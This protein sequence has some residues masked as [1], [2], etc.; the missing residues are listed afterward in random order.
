MRHRIPAGNLD[1]GHS[2]ARIWICGRFVWAVGLDS[3]PSGRMT[4]RL[5]PFLGREGHDKRVGPEAIG[6]LLA[7]YADDYRFIDLCERVA[8]LK[9]HRRKWGHPV[10]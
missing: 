10:S 9:P 8:G 2:L 3:K 6:A 5:R 4:D 7:W 1:R